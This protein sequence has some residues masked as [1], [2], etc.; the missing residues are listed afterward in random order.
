MR[1]F[2][3][4]WDR[5]VEATH[6]LSQTGGFRRMRNRILA[7]ARLTPRDRVV[8]VGT[9][10]GL[11][12]LGIA[13]TVS[14]VRAVDISPAMTS[15]L[16]RE[17]ARLGLE[18]L[19]PITATAIDLP[20]ADGSATVVVSNYVYHHLSDADK[21]D[22]IAEAFRVLRPGGRIVI[23]DMMFRPEIS[24]QRT[25]RIIRAKVVSLLRRGPAGV[26]RLI[27][28]L[29]R[30]LTGSWEQPADPE[31]WR[32][33]LRRAGFEQIEVEPLEHEGGILSAVKPT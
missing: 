9:G 12:A 15:Y 30:Y 18:N 24:D 14:D 22:G 10:T 17:A 25:R 28:N 33:A 21:R 8:D 26:A 4:D 23:G 29:F 13:P 31:W 20:L 16:G 32:E 3:K 2:A 11:L 6:E 7:R 27:K 19:Q 5:H 1:P